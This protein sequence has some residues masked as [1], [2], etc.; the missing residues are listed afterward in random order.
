M[1]SENITVGMTCKVQNKSNENL[2]V[3]KKLINVTIVDQNDNNVYVDDDSKEVKLF[4]E[5][6]DFYQV[7]TCQNFDA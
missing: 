3:V 4:R 1:Q 5:D 6:P 2:N 7:R